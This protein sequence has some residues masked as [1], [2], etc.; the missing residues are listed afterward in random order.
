MKKLFIA[1]IL[2]I[3]VSV[4]YACPICGCGGGNLYMGLFP[5]F[6][7]KFIGIRWNYAAYHTHLINDPAQFSHNYYNSTEIWGGINIGKR[8]QVLAFLPY[9]SNIQFDDDAGHTTKSGLGD[10]TLLGNYK[11][12]DT[13][14]GNTSSQ[15][16]W[17]GGGV[18][19][20][21]GS[22]NVDANNPST[23][24]ADINAQIGTGSVDLFLNA[25][26][27]FQF[28]DFGINTSASY[29]LGMA[30]SQ[31]YKYGNKLDINSIAFYQLK[32]K[33]FI[34]APNAGLAYE[35]TGGNRLNKQ[36]IYLSDGLDAGSFTTGGHA[37]NCLAGV[38]VNFKKIT[39]GANIQSPISQQFAAG[40]TNLH[41]KAMVHVTFSL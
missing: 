34:I 20:P 5:N 9:H 36:Q 29:K 8:W 12:S 18:K 24:L 2:L 7:S 37:L 11:L 4:S 31:H 13:R 16:V 6:K 30:N 38:E 40:Q 14:S 15:Q 17:I 3:V 33:R 27:S 32:T 26:H 35:N 25:R 41:M 10:I 28:K 19:I 39:V 23:T 22:F 1:A 21:S